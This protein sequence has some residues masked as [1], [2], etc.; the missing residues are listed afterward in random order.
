[1]PPSEDE[2]RSILPFASHEAMTWHPDASFVNRHNDHS[3]KLSN[4]Y[5]MDLSLNPFV[6]MGVRQA[7]K[8]YRDGSSECQKK[9]G[10]RFWRDNG[11][12]GQLTCGLLVRLRL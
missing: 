1:M 8:K 9:C 7:K 5:C 10:L 4:V 2:V 12:E 3:R 6:P 11:Y